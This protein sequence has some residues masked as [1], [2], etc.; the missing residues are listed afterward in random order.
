MMHC[1]RSSVF[2]CNMCERSKAQ[3]IC[4]RLPSRTQKSISYISLCFSNALE[5]YLQ[6]VNQSLD[7]KQLKVKFT[8]SNTSAVDSSF[9]SFISIVL[10]IQRK[11]YRAKYFCSGLQLPKVKFQFK[12]FLY[13]KSKLNLLIQNRVAFNFFRE[14]I[15]IVDMFQKNQ[16]ARAQRQGFCMSNSGNKIHQFA[17]NSAKRR[18][19]IRTRV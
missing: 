9:K 12:L 5:T 16:N 13:K 7:L 15:A 14:K 2:V 11:I 6:K 8:G 18:M 10:K 19:Q 3:W 17:N 1:S 4:S